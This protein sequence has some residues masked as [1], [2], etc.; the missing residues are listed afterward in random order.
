M[1]TMLSVGHTSSVSERPQGVSAIATFLGFLA[2]VSFTFA[3]LLVTTRVSLS[4]GA[5]LVG[6]GLEQ[7]GPLVF[8]LNSAV[9]GL[10]AVGL[11]KGWRWSRL[12]TILFAA[13]GVLLAVPATSSAVTDLRTLAVAREGLGIMA[14]VVVIYYLTQEPAKEWFA[15]R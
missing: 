2:V 14:R 10:L 12:A 3:A 5:F 9:T 7:L 11:W 4:A 1:L 13:A 8:L 6:G 15:A